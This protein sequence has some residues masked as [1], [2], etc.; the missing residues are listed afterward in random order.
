MVLCKSA[1]IV[2]W[3]VRNEGSAVVEVLVIKL[4]VVHQLRQRDEACMID[5][6]G[7]QVAQFWFWFWPVEYVAVDWVLATRLH[8]TTHTS[9]Q[10]AKL[11][12]VTQTNS[13]FD[14]SIMYCLSC[15]QLLSA[16]WTVMKN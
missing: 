1:Y 5:I 6:I 12:L 2:S 8:N 10:I 15:S 9:W 4:T 3:T 11:M 7:F 16:S 13:E 14:W